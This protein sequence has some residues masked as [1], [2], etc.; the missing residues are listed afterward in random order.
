MDVAGEHA[1]AEAFFRWVGRTLKKY[2][3][4]VDD[5]QHHLQAGIPLGKDDLLH[6]R[7]TLDG[8]EVTADNG[9]GNF[10]IDGYG[11]WLWALAEHVRLTAT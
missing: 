3:S 9:W 6:T 5:V 10:Q 1:S 11:T 7:Y 2:G 8:H 4:K